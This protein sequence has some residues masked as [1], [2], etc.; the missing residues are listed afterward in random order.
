MGITMSNGG[1]PVTTATY[2]STR[3][4]NGAGANSIGSTSDVAQTFAQCATLNTSTNMAHGTIDF[5]SPFVAR[6]TSFAGQSMMYNF[7]STNYAF[8][9]QWAG[10]QSGST[11]FDGFA[12]S[13]GSVMT[14]IITVYGYRKV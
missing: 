14:G 2:A 9:Q 11:S 1:T 7:Q 3:I 10:S 12:M 4:Y 6:P 8:F 5:F 13:S